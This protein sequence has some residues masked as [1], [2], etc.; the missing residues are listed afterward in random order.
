M[1]KIEKWIIKFSE[2]Y[3]N[4]KKNRSNSRRFKT[5]YSSTQ[6]DKRNDIAKV[7]DYVLWRCFIFFI[8]FILFFL[9]N[10]N[11]YSAIIMATMV[12][13]IYHAISIK[14]R[15][16]KLN[17]LKIEKRRI[18][19]SQRVYK[20]ILNKTIDEMKEYI[21]TIFTK[22]GFTKIQYINNDHKSIVLIADYNDHKTMLSCYTYKNDF[23]VE[24]KDLKEFLCQLIRENIKKGIFVTTSDFTKDCYDY[25]NQIN[26]NYN[27]ILINKEKLLKII[28]VKDMFP[29]EQEVDEAIENQISK[30]KKNWG[31]YKAAALS[32]KKIKGYFTLS[33]F[34][35]GT[36]LY[37]PYTVYYI[38]V[39][40]ITMFLTI[41]TFIFHIHNKENNQE[42]KWEDIESL[43]QNL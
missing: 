28:E 14:I 25:L 33:I 42:E 19:A 16:G 31:R 8:T 35:M 6:E 27:V 2:I 40:S 41:I 24:L 38:V 32:N 5:F 15:R 26:E 20:E 29:T 30:R 22:V 34:L 21:T 4:F 36:S 12:S 17:E 1:K 7:I 39:A 3:K 18:V 13:C 37:I 11:I 43:F 9:K 10:A 23:D